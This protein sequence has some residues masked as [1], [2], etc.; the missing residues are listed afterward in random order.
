V[1]LP[2]RQSR[3]FSD[4]DPTLHV[5]TANARVVSERIRQ[6]VQELVPGALA[7]MKPM[8]DAVAV[9]TIPA[10]V[11]AMV[12]GAFGLLGGFLAMLGI[13]GL[14]SY[15]LVQRSREVAIRRAI[16]ASTRHIIRVVVGSSAAL[17]LGGLVVGVTAAALAA[18]L[19]GGLL[20]NV[21]PRD[22]LVVAATALTILSTAVIASAPLAFRAA[23][24]DPLTSLKA[25]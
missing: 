14:I 25:D 2:S 11:G 8:S 18:P 20:V 10:R 24:I 4:P 21:S 5:R 23:R 1:Y 13:Y 19:L 6:R 9:A 22:P 3:A 16:G 15:I 7:A 12:M 17:A